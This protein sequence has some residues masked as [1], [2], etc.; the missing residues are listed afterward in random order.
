MAIFSKVQ[1]FREAGM[2]NCRA[3]NAKIVSLGNGATALA[4]TAKSE[5]FGNFAYTSARLTTLKHPVAGAIMPPKYANG[6][7][8]NGGRVKVAMRAKLPAGT[9]SGTWP[10]FWMLPSKPVCLLSEY[11]H[12]NACKFAH[13]RCEQVL[14][15]R[16]SQAKSHCRFHKSCSVG[17]NRF[18]EDLATI[19]ADVIGWKMY[20]F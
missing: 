20:Y 19:I 8:V 18:E 4:I 2:N 11:L 10:A 13:S 12:K 1:F 6:T 9:V 5:A 17:V 14:S 7:W 3:D 15:I 16:F